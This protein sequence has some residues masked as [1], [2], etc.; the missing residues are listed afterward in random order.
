MI[1][2]KKLTQAQKAKLKQHAKNYSM[3][4]I[5]SMRMNMMR[6]KTFKE[7][8]IIATKKVGL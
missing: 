3:K 6:G 1:K 4:H 7:S 5:A 2:L 8:H